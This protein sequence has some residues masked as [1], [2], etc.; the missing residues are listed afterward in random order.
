MQISILL[1]GFAAASTSAQSVI[2]SLW[3]GECFYPAADIGFDLDSYVNGGRWYQVAGTVA[4]FTAACKCIYAQYALTDEGTVAVNNTCEVAGQAVNIIGAASPA[5]ATYG[6]NGVLRVQ[7]PGTPEPECR[8]PNYIVQDYT[9]DFAIVQ[10]ANFSTLFVLS[11]QQHLE[12]SVLDAWIE[13][14]GRL[15]S[16]LADVVKTDQSNCSFV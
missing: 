15:G 13:R 11:R 2:P 8:G 9:G 1:A 12:E 16:N 14:A 6:A 4:P 3:D 7:F 10:S 5:N